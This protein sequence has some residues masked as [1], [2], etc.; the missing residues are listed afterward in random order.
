MLEFRESE[1]CLE[2]RRWIAENLTAA[3]EIRAE[4]GDAKCRV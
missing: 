2:K 3:Q 1:Q 4:L